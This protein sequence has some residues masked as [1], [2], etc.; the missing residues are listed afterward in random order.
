MT[1][2]MDKREKEGKSGSGRLFNS[3]LLQPSQLQSRQ[4]L[5][6]FMAVP[7]QSGTMNVTFS[8]SK[9]TEDKN[10]HIWPRNCHAQN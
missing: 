4:L 1:Y 7:L 6:C 2:S 3:L 9:S 8:T 5:L 10:M